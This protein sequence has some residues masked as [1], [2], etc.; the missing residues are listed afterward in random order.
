[1]IPVLQGNK[2]KLRGFTWADFAA[3][4]AMWQEPEVAEF[5]PFAPVSPTQSWSRFNGNIFSWV[6]NGFG[7]WAVV[8]RSELFLGTV[9]FFRR[10]AGFGEDYDRA[11]Q[12]GWV[13]AA[14][15]RG[16]GNAGEAVSLAH[17]WLD[18]QPFGGR[19][20]CGVDP[21][22]AASIRVAIK[23]GYRVMRT[24]KD[25]WGPVQLMERIAPV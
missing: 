19:S 18:F 13:F 3:F 11:I 23:T 24:E 14:R 20:V 8:D 25:A 12:A 5:I 4:S 1:M 9:T 2:V 17:S 15:G 21:Q 10:A 6:K 16:Q 22:H 7:G